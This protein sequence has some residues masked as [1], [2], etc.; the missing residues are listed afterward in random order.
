MLDCAIDVCSIVLHLLL[1]LM[2]FLLLLLLLLIRLLLLIMLLFILLL[3]ILLLILLLLV[4]LLLLIVLL[5]LIRLVWLLLAL[6]VHIYIHVSMAFCCGL[7]VGVL[8]HLLFSSL[9]CLY[10]N[11]LTPK[12]L[13]FSSN[14]IHP[15]TPLGKHYG[16]FALGFRQT[17][18]LFLVVKVPLNLKETPVQ[19]DS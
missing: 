4:V 8:F 18:H 6:L 10:R 11:P 16:T 14:L 17:F 5:F 7:H 2:I 3:L 15:L 19:V 12:L 9:H 1:R 13:M